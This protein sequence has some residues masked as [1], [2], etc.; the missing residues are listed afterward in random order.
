MVTV[1]TSNSKNLI[2]SPHPFNASEFVQEVMQFFD[3]QPVELS[4][5]EIVAAFD[6]FT[7]LPEKWSG[8]KLKQYLTKSNLLTYSRAKPAG[9]QLDV[10]PL[11]KIQEKF[12]LT[13][14]DQN[15]ASS[16]KNPTE[17]SSSGSESRNA[18][19][20]RT[21]SRSLPEKK[22][23][24]SSTQTILNS[25]PSFSRY[26]MERIP[27]QAQVAL[28]WGVAHINSLSLKK[29]DTAIEYLTASKMFF[30][31]QYEAEREIMQAI[32]ERVRYM[33]HL[34]DEMQEK[35]AQTAFQKYFFEMHNK[36]KFDKIIEKWGI[37]YDVEECAYQCWK[38]LGRKAKKIPLS[39]F[40]LRKMII[41]ALE[42]QYPQKMKEL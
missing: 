2:P 19:K 13:L 36:G 17:T 16:N 4:A 3:Q 42:T 40:G 7:F 27:R 15:P 5:K 35:L 39:D 29:I 23:T 12:Q 14:S 8:R 33:S 21:P 38:K 10:I 28:N 18:S 9:Y 24:D 30:D 41:K 26:L 31:S 6:Q 32:D 11:Q 34:S 25:I 22:R 1:E 20:L 37:N